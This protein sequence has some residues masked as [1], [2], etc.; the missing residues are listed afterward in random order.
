MQRKA[1]RDAQQQFQQQL[2]ASSMMSMQQVPTQFQYSELAQLA[3]AALVVVA[4]QAGG[5][6]GGAVMRRRCASH[7]APG[8]SSGAEASQQLTG[9]EVELATPAAKSRDCY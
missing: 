7:H 1:G 2:G 8:S 9:F 3:P 4:V 6:A 5:A